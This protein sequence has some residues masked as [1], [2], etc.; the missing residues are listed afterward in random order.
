MV[1]KLFSLT[2]MKVYLLLVDPEEGGCAQAKICEKLAISKSTV[3]YHTKGLEAEGFVKPVKG[4]K[5]P[6]LYTKGPHSNTLD[7]VILDLGVRTNAG[8]VGASPSSNKF[9]PPLNTP[10]VK[11]PLNTPSSPSALNIIEPVRV[12]L[13]GGVSFPVEKIG[14]LQELLIKESGRDS[15]SIKLFDPRPL[16]TADKG[17][18]AVCWQGKIGFRGKEVKLHFWQGKMKNTLI[19]WPGEWNEVAANL[20]E[21]DGSAEAVFQSMA[22]DIANVLSKHGGWRFGLPELTGSVEYASKDE[23]ILSQIPEDIR[24]LR[25]SPDI[26]MD[27]SE[28]KGKRELETNKVQTARAIFDFPAVRDKVESHARRFYVLETDIDRIVNILE[29][30]AKAALVEADISTATI[31]RNAAETAEKMADRTAR[32]NAEAQEESI[33]AQE[34]RGRYDFDYIA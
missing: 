5:S 8:S 2:R 16:I 9:E 27:E 19:V 12:H 28:G 17:R 26:W 18:G 1:S 22:Q 30:L 11:P 13:N 14:D 29:R 20:P 33:V 3:S 6:I 25:G 21:E 34:V 15:R 23:R 32:K 10:P 7:R 31:A 24:A 4:A